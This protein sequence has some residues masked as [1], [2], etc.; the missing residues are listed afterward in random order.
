[1]PNYD[2][3]FTIG[4]LVGVLVLFYWPWQGLCI[5]FARQIIFE[6][7]EKLFDLAMD[8]RLN[9]KSDEYRQIRD[10]LNKSIRFSH[11]MSLWKFA[12]NRRVLAR[13]R[14]TNEAPVLHDIVRSISDHS[15][16]KAVYD[17]VDKSSNA[18]VAAMAL[19][20]L[21]TI[22]VLVFAWLVQQ[23]GIRTGLTRKRRQFE[24]AVQHDVEL[25][26]TYSC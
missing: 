13:Y 20:S 26:P 8:G 25:A 19:R 23:A 5:E 18:L 3:L 9:F 7:R 12:A 24:R 4:C 6:E 14:R 16:R 10:F 2:A 1:M 21:P 15:T 11:E 17:I 22:I